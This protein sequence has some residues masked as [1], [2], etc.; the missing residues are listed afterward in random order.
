[1]NCYYICSGILNPLDKMQEEIFV[2][3]NNI[4]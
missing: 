2:F 3:I 1:M 4:N